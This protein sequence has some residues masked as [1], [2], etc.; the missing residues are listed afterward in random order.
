MQGKILIKKDEGDYSG[1]QVFSQG[2]SMGYLFANIQFYDKLGK[3]KDVT[4]IDNSAVFFGNTIEAKKDS[5]FVTS[6][7]GTLSIIQLIFLF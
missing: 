1:W 2:K 4:Q 5:I 7:Y 3:K 6:I